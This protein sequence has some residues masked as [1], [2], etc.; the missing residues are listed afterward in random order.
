MGR[1]VLGTALVLHGLAHTLAGLRAADRATEAW[2]FGGPLGSLQPWL[3]AVIWTVAAGG[4]V[5]AGLGRW[6]AAI[7]RRWW[8]HAAL[9]GF[10]ASVVLLVLGWRGDAAIGMVMNV[11]LIGWAFHRWQ[12]EKRLAAADRIPSRSRARMRQMGRGLAHTAASV[13]LAYL[14]LV[15][16]ARP[17]YLTWGS[18][19]E[20]LRRPLPGDGLIEPRNFV[21]QHAV[22]IHRPADQV[23]PWLIQIGQDR[24]GFYSY[25]W[26]ENLFGLRIRNAERVVPEWQARA[27]GDFV[28]AAPPD[29]VGGRLARVAG[30]RVADLEPG[31]SLVLENWGAFVLIPVDEN[32][33]RFVIRS[34]IGLDGGVWAR[35]LDL[36][37]FEPPHFVMQRKMMLTIKQ[38]AEQT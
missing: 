1:L 12:P 23:W 22:T 11:V 24:G 19:A 21:V 25:G 27:V 10:T 9:G 36:L 3:V 34:G 2:M 38:R 7:A 35:P 20:E 16:L 17:F 8:R 6:G 18:T 37:L 30:W 31:R 4:W 5:A 28:P 29:W 13:F 14:V 15:L 33:T 32:T 26:L